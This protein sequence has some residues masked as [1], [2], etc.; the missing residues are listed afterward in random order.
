MTGLKGEKNYGWLG[1]K[2]KYKSL[3]IW[4]ERQLGLAKN[5]MCLSCH[6]K[7]GSKAMNW[8][9]I[10]HKYTRDLSKWV[11]LCKK[12]HSK[13]DQKMFKSY[14]RSKKLL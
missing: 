10:D 13:Y 5:K 4:I 7:S 2:V 3:H 8:S 11:P 1:D 6:G 12:C 9:N 14:S